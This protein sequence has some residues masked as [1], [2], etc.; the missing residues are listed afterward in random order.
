MTEAGIKPGPDLLILKGNEMYQHICTAEDP[1]NPNE[2]DDYAKHPD[3]HLIDESGDDGTK[4][5]ECPH[6][7]LILREDQIDD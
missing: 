5:Y 2:H 3:L 6:C 1:W 7:W 4:R